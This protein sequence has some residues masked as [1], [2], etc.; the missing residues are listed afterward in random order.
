MFSAEMSDRQYRCHRRKRQVLL[1]DVLDGIATGE[2]PEGLTTDYLI[3]T[4]FSA[5]WSEQRAQFA[6]L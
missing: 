1:D 5:V 6:S 4:R 3:K 2:Q